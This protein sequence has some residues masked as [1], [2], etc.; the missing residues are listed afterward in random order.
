MATVEVELRDARNVPTYV[1]VG[2]ST[3]GSGSAKARA[4]EE[5]LP[6]AQRL[7]MLLDVPGPSWA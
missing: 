2:R 6:M 3:W 1:V 7:A 4:R 5:L